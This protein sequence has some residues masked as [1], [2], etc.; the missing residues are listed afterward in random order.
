[1]Y[2]SAYMRFLNPTAKPTPRRT[3]TDVGGAAGAA[4][5]G[6]HVV[7]PRGAGSGS[8]AHAADDLGDR[9]RAR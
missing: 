1:M 5:A 9:Q 8:A 2:P 4:G 7:R 3:S 6:E